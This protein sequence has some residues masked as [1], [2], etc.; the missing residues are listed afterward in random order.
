MAALA[1]GGV[2]VSAKAGSRRWPGRGVWTLS[3]LLTRAAWGYTVDSPT[4]QAC[5]ERITSQALRAIRLEL[6]AAG[7]LAA[8][9]NERALIDDLQFTPDD[10][11]RDLGAATLL[12]GVRDNDLKGRGSLDLSQ[13][14]LVHGDPG[15][16]REHCLRGADQKEPGGSAI[17]VRECRAFIQ[18][19]VAEAL[20][21]LDVAGH[22]D[23][24]RRT[25]LGLHLELRH[26]VDAP[27]PTYYVRIGQALHT[28]EDSFSH[29]FRTPDGLAITVVLDWV[30]E[31][32][33]HLV[34]A[35]DGPPHSQ[36]LDRCDDPDALRTRRRMLATEAAA[37]ILRATL[38]PGQT[39]DQ[40]VAA[41]DAVLERY[42]SY[43]P[44]CT[45]DNNWCDDPERK[46]GNGSPL[47]CAVTGGRPSWLA[48]LPLLLLALRRR[49]RLVALLALGGLTG[50]TRLDHA[51]AAP[52][53]PAH[54]E[55]PPIR[56]PE[57]GP[58]DPSRMA[59][60]GYVGVS[61]ALANAAMAFALGGRLRLSKHWGVG[62]DAEWNPWIRYNGTA[63]RAGVFN[64]YGTVF[65]RLP[66]AY[67]QFNLRSTAN[68]GV[69][70][71]LMDL[72]GAPKGTT[73]LYFGLSPLGLEWKW[74]RNF[75]LIVN[76]LSFAE[77]IPQMKGVP[78]NYPQYR[79]TIGLETALPVGGQ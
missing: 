26:H 13:L 62:L 72:Y 75:Y 47:G 58:Q 51:T 10:D 37:A 67:A 44:G 73:G 48:G 40:K 70:R 11:M 45:F 54:S 43:A 76:P 65:A 12:A 30:D 35:R 68:L 53:E 49:R 33:G 36:E 59:A 60:G 3:L 69:S 15:S 1:G 7:P 14:S 38:A 61:G 66:L 79:T 21:G 23:P 28:V 46:Y 17:A 5:H 63:L 64:G 77:P 16:Q 31:A 52:G 9:R 2:R 8:D 22:P 19:K 39:R 78:F 6:P 41:V 57:P 25:T 32:N 34:V 4:T 42:L 71:M 55:P 56:V 27:L 29:T 24:N 18:Q 74:S 20:D 50:A